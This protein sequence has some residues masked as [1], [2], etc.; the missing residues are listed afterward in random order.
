[1]AKGFGKSRRAIPWMLLGQA[2]LI[3]RD[4]WRDLPEV[5]RARVTELAKKS[6]GRP[7]GLTAAERSELSEIARR[8]DL[9]KLGRDLG[10]LAAKRALAGKGLRRVR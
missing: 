1:M 5:D 9:K 4:H 2:A 8:A 7:T 6:K 3:V 10:P